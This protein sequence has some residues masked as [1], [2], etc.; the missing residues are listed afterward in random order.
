M[1]KCV[2]VP[3]LA[4]A[5]AVVCLAAEPSPKAA[6]LYFRAGEDAARKGDSLKAYLLYTQA[7]RLNPSD[8]LIRER[9]LA[10][11]AS[12]ALAGRR[13][14]SDPANETIAAKLEAEGLTRGER[15]EADRAE[16]PATLSGAAGKQSF[17]LR[18]DSRAVIEKV[19]G[20]FGIQVV[21]DAA[22]QPI[23]TL[24]F[25]VA[26]VTYQEALRI[27]EK[28][29]DSFL[30]PMSSNLALVARD[31][32]QNRTQFTPVMAIAVPIPERISSQEA[33]EIATAVQQTMEIRRITL[34]P[35][36]RVVYFRDSVSKVQA[37]REMFSNL[38]RLR[39]QVEVEVEFV[40][41]SRTSSLSYGLSL[42]TASSI[43]D[44]SRSLAGFALGAP[45][46]GN[47]F[48]F[49]GGATFLGLG[50]ANA[51][52]FA[53][54]SRASGESVLSS[55]IFGLDGQ[56]V[57]LHIGDRYPVIAGT[58]TG[59]TPDT[60]VSQTLAPTINYQDLGLVLKVTPMVHAD[61]EVSLDVDAQFK[62][63]GAGGANGIP[64]IA[65]RQYQ[66][67]VRM[68]Q[69]EW[70]VLAGLVSTTETETL[71]G[72]AGLASLPGVGR[73][74][75]RRTKLLET[76]DTLLVLKPRIVALP[77]WEEATSTI[78]TGS[79]TRPLTPYRQ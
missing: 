58:F 73:L 23:P 17:D 26:D 48:A 36:R 34:D 54:L 38:A 51:T 43:V 5:A 9:R 78:W 12:P 15:L 76:S 47:Y 44:F 77:P 64:V 65:S 40:S 20:A 49:G 10:M 57:S 55:Q 61:G 25:R 50:I 41:V 24:L 59:L 19:A 42:P 11:Q 32:T 16:P 52:A 2:Q 70:A 21:F 63:L 3:L 14:D 13:L 46:A 68:K 37:A 62:T 28:S 74:F 1:Q 6:A 4:F 69:G 27:L 67:K 35:A 75:S 30:A 45:P 33:Q 71:T 53:T 72:I 8:A 79:Q 66:G 60:N 18:A 22:Y 31:T 56:A 7:A 29:T 39:A